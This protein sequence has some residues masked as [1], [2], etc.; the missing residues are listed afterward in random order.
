MSQTKYCCSLKAKYFPPRC[1]TSLGHQG[2]EEFSEGVPNSL[3]YVQ[4]IFPGGRKIL[5]GEKHSLLPLFIGLPPQPT[6]SSPKAHFLVIGMRGLGMQ[7]VLYEL[8]VQCTTILQL[9]RHRCTRNTC[10]TQYIMHIVGG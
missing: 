6:Q 1:V 8:E 5:N 2:S 7:T 3:N 9:P 4:H 10:Q